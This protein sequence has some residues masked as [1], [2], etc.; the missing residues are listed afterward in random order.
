MS[1]ARLERPN[2]SRRPA[3]LKEVLT[4]FNFGAVDLC[5]VTDRPT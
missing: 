1:V 2:V 4:A 3:S 5:E